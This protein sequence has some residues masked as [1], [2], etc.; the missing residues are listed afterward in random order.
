MK[1]DQV[2][3]EF[4]SSC[5]LVL[6]RSKKFEQVVNKSFFS[7]PIDTFN[8]FPMFNFYMIKVN[9]W[10]PSL[11]DENATFYPIPILEYRNIGQCWNKY[12][13][14]QNNHFIKIPGECEITDNVKSDCRT[15]SPGTRYVLCWQKEDRNKKTRKQ[16]GAEKCQ[17]QIMLETSSAESA[18]IGATSWAKLIVYAKKARFSILTFTYNPRQSRVRQGTELQ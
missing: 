16:T 14:Y 10:P 6:K 7:T 4:W 1:S 5:E 15:N 2:M 9:F 13:K 17:A 8:E 3:K 11:L 12:S 18:T